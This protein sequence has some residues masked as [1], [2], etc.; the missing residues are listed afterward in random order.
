VRFFIE[1]SPRGDWRVMVRGESAPV[2]VHDTEEEAQER[3]AAY[4][5][6]VAA[7]AAPTAET[8]VARGDRVTLRD[9]SEVIV[10]PVTP[11][12]KPLLLEGFAEFSEQSRYQRFLGFKKSLTAG[13]LDYLTNVDH[14]EH[15]AIGALDPASGRGVGIA[16]FIRVRPGSACAE[17]A[18]A[19]ADAWQG[20]GVGGVL[21]DRLVERAQAVGVTEFT[22]SLLVEN[23]AMLALFA[24][25][26]RMEV[27]HDAGSTAHIFVTFDTSRPGDLREALRASA[28]QL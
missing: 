25:L 10:R 15:E 27:R 12:D 3:L 16:R 18:V 17:A 21:L 23:R 20:K 9:G 24:R 2:S 6:G 8:G 14:S 11:E 4:A 22:A 26:G 5:R 1:Q 19:V 7:A 28:A 13:E